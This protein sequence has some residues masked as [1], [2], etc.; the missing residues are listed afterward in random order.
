MEN[1]III[2]IDGYSSTGKSTLAQT[3]AQKLYYN[4]IDSGA[5]YRAVTLLALH[6]R[7]FDTNPWD[8]KKLLDLL[9]TISLDF[10]TNELTGARC[11]LLN[12]ENIEAKIRMMAVSEKVS[13]IASVPEVREKLLYLQQAMGR[14]KGIV[15]DGR[16][17]GSVVFPEA[18]L[19]IFLNASLE[20]RAARRYKELT[21]KG[22]ETT[23]E[24]VLSNLIE[25]DRLDSSR[26]I[27]PLVQPTNAVEIDNTYLS[28]D[29]Q[30]EYVYQLALDKVY[31]CS[32]KP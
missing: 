18:A 22:Q 7:L 17:I 5:M 24:K 11:I 32:K 26:A 1:K 28:P 10:Q 27:A 25:R 15:M 23:Y 12:G 30:L 8:Q 13:L 29:A 2:A 20:A 31:P 14:D 19:K 3:L 16:D 6:K 21:E 4:Y 9:P